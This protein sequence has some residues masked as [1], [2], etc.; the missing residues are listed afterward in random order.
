MFRSTPIMV[1]PY[2][3]QPHSSFKVCPSCQYHSKGGSAAEPL[4]A[5][6]TVC[7]PGAVRS[8]YSQ[9]TNHASEIPTAFPVQHPMSAH[10]SSPASLP[11]PMCVV[12]TPEGLHMS[13]V[14]YLSCTPHL[15]EHTGDN[16]C[17]APHPL[18]PQT[19]RSLRCLIS[20]C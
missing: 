14:A 8:L 9:H 3:S 2:V 15:A 10:P 12:P 11:A 7:G 13:H 19:V 1:M 5:R 20:M 16:G 18:P 6:E 4:T 17:S